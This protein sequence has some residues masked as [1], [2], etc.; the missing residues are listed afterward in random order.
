MI[1]KRYILWLSFIILLLLTGVLIFS[2]IF[3]HYDKD[4]YT[5]PK[6]ENALY[7]K[8]RT[9]NFEISPAKWET[10]KDPAEFGNWKWHSTGEYRVTERPN[11]TSLPL[12]YC[13]IEAIE[14][15]CSNIF[16]FKLT[17]NVYAPKGVFNIYLYECEIIQN[18][19][20]K[21]NSINKKTYIISNVSK[22]TEGLLTLANCEVPLKLDTEY[23]AYTQKYI[24]HSGQSDILNSSYYL[25][26]GGFSI[27][28]VNNTFQESVVDINKN[29]Y[30][31]DDIKNNQI[32]C[33]TEKDKTLYNSNK[34][35]VLN[36]YL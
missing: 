11:M 15:D 35:Y 13:D 26:S 28:E 7:N 9:L 18:L 22:Y 3:V 17:G 8:N 4:L 6:D 31:L 29:D 24:S 1:K 12:N 23:I 5:L 27:Y 19:K 32:N 36:K 10:T 25:Y 20:N 16:R 2:A 34:K 33:F 21:A 14:K 30:T